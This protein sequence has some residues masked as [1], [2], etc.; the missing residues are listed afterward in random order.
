MMSEVIETEL[1]EEEDQG[2][3][4]LQ[5]GYEIK[6]PAVPMQEVQ[7]EREN[8]TPGYNLWSRS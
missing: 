3:V 5:M 7:D 2:D 1:P 6:E 8:Y 4:R